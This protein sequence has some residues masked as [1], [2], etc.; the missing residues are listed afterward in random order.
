MREAPSVVIIERLLEL[1]AVVRAHDPEAIREATKIFGSRVTFS[2]NPYDILKGA[3]ALGIV[4]EWNE[5]RNPDFDRIKSLLTSPMIF[6]G[7][8]L[9]QPRR[10]KDAGFHYYPIGR[11]CKSFAEG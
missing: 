4:T 5:Y 7:R 3:D 10:M 8:N 2:H 6:D 1:G 9:Y 11:N